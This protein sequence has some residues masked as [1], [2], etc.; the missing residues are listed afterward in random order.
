[1]HGT[2]SLI[3]CPLQLERLPKQMRLHDKSCDV[4]WEN[5][6]R[7]LFASRGFHLVITIGQSI[8]FGDRAI[9]LS[10]QIPFVVF[11]IFTYFC[12]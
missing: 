3:E 4:L 10:F 9:D 5:T 12:S 7:G 2:E 6:K 11:D 8:P 1:M